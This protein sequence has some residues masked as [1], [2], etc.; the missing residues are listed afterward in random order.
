MK[1]INDELFT[2]KRSMWKR[3]RDGNGFEIKKKK[4]T[5]YVRISNR[6]NEYPG[7]VLL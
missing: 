3:A 1:D 5:I 2:V 4:N 6:A 7:R